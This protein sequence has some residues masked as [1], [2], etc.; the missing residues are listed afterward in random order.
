LT[1]SK[2]NCMLTHN[3]QACHFLHMPVTQMTFLHVTRLY[4]TVIILSRIWQR[5]LYCICTWW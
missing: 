5:R 1:C 2:Q 4:S 3:F